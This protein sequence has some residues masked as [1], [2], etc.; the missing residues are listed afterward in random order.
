MNSPFPLRAIAG[1]FALACF[2]VALLAGLAADR[3]TGAILR[4]AILAL[5][6]GQFV[7][8]AGGWALA[9]SFH[10][11]LDAHRRSTANEGAGPAGE[12]A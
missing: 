4:T 12:Q 1:C 6:V 5:I 8:L 10:E 3:D 11:A 7:G 2:G 9:R